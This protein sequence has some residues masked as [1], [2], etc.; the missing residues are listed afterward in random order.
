VLALFRSDYFDVR[1]ILLAIFLVG[2][3]VPLAASV[4]LNWLLLRSEKFYVKLPRTRAWHFALIALSALIVLL[5]SRMYFS[6]D[7]HLSSYALYATLADWLWL[8]SQ[9]EVYAEIEIGIV[10]SVT[11][12]YMFVFCVFVFMLISTMHTLGWFSHDC[13][14]QRVISRPLLCFHVALGAVLTMI[15]LVFLFDLWLAITQFIEEVQLDETLLNTWNLGNIFFDVVNVILLFVYAL[16]VFID[17][18]KLWRSREKIVFNVEN[19][20]Q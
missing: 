4:K 3:V 7:R 15:V 17:G 8:P 1:E 19:P 20:Q 11:G 12:I 14:E 2:A 18:I 5:A 6:Y 9:V 10:N 13:M 16:W